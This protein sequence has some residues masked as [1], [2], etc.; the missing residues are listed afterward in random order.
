VVRCNRPRREHPCRVK[1]KKNVKAESA[2]LPALIRQAAEEA[3]AVRRQVTATGVEM[4]L[5]EVREQPFNRPDWIF[6]IKL[7][8]YRLLA[9]TSVGK[10]Q[11]V[12]RNGHDLAGT[13]PEVARAVES[14]PFSSVVLDGEVVAMDDK[15]R[16]SFQRLQQR[17]KLTRAPDVHRV[18]AEVPAV[19]FAFDLLG[20]EDLDLRPLPLTKRKD[21]LRRV[22]PQSGPVRFLDHVEGEGK[23]LY[24]HVIALGLEGIV[25][26]KADCPYRGGRSPHWLKIRADRTDDFVVVGYTQPRGARHG[27]GALHVGQYVE[28]RLVYAGRVGTGFSARQLTEVKL[29]LDKIERKTPPCEGPVPAGATSGTIPLTAIPD[30]RTATWVEPEMVGEVRFKEWTDEGY[31]RQPAFLRFR[32]DKKPEDCVRQLPPVNDAKKKP[33]KPSSPS[34]PPA[35]RVK[36]SNRDKIFWPEDGYTKGYLIDYYHAISPWLLPYLERRPVVLTRYPDGIHGKSFFQKDAPDHSP[37]WLRTERMWSENASREID[38]F[39]CDTEDALLYLANMAAIPLH[40]WASRLPT[41]ERPDWCSLDLDPKGAPFDH[42]VEV[43]QAARE[44]C[45]R[46]DLP[47]FIKTT[48]SSGLHVMI[49]LGGHFTH[50]EAKSLGEVLAHALVRQLP[51]IA[52]T[53]RAITR[54][55]GKVYVDYLQNGHGKLLVSPYSVRPLPGAPVSMP[56]NWIEVNQQLDIRAFTIRNAAERMKKLKKDPLIDILHTEPHMSR[57]LDRLHA[58]FG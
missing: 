31:L 48:G 2:D 33:A 14:L 19:F 37:G 7:D 1:P 47:C 52:T 50:D 40:I 29:R 34:K 17:G 35:S 36:F 54:R 10:V 42:V 55:E 44:L 8:G 24:D 20:F 26:K 6:E 18:A 23:A 45:H 51:R 57:V 53:T 4:M 27:F 22:I 28:G 30:F 32:D 25:A 3:G 15:G 56:L 9:G 16:P 5:A 58:E 49:P 12:S 41:L 21:L 46:I 38:Y 13:F 11:L 43:A 39:I